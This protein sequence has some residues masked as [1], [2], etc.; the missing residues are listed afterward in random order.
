MSGNVAL[1]KCKFA[2]R[3]NYTGALRPVRTHLYNAV[4]LD[5][6]SRLDTNTGTWT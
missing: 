5:V 1:N 6:L 3:P 2:P 4:L